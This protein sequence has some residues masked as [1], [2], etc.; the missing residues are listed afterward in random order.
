MI[1]TLKNVDELSLHESGA[2]T[3]IQVNNIIKYSQS[4]EVPTKID[5]DKIIYQA[6]IN[7]GKHSK[8]LNTTRP[9]FSYNG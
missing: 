4:N 3:D 6:L 9:K 2:V 5:Y 1:V 8:V 7:E